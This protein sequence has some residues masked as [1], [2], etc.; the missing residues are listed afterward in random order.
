MQLGSQASEELTEMQMWET[1]VS[2]CL[3]RAGNSFKGFRLKELLSVS[4]VNPLVLNKINDIS[5]L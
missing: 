1:L 5:D 2:E 3:Q 4:H